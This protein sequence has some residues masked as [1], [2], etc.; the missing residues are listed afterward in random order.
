M[1]ALRTWGGRSQFNYEGSVEA[2]TYIT[3][4]KRKNK[5]R[6]EGH[7]YAALRH[8]FLNQVV[9]LGT[10]RKTSETEP[11]PGSLGDWLH[12]N[13]TYAAIA[14]YVGPILVLEDYAERVGKHDIRI[15]L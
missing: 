3:Y 5:A 11:P 15:I 9:P 7:Q 14:S 1:P 10:T 12:A 4:G 6:V 2:G 13:V 8:Q